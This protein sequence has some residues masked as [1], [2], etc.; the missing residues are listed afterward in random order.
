MTSIKYDYMI[1]QILKSDFGIVGSNITILEEF[2]DKTGKDFKNI[3]KIAEQYKETENKK[4]IYDEY[5]IILIVKKYLND[6]LL[7]EKE[8]RI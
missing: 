5:I 2:I 8:I 7:I 6:K 1:Q 3:K 4:I